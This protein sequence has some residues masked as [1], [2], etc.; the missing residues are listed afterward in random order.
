[1]ELNKI[2]NIF[3]VVLYV[4]G[5]WFFDTYSPSINDYA[6][7][8]LIND[9]PKITNWQVFYYVVLNFAWFFYLIMLRIYEYSSNYRFLYLILGIGFGIDIILNLSKIG[10]KF[11][12]Y[13]VSINNIEQNV[14][15]I[16]LT[17]SLLIILLLK[18]LKC[19]RH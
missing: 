7:I 6:I 2:L 9:S 15:I 12:D 11:T 19:L 10:L 14:L 18:I 13:V 17:T 3:P 5:R 16:S 8:T 4:I 1:M